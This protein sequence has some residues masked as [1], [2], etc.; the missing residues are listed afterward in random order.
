MQ[1]GYIDPSAGFAGLFGSVCC[2]LYAIPAM[3]A[4]AGT[5][6]WI[7]ALVDVLQRKDW[8]FPSA[9]PGSNDRVLWVLV[10]LFTHLIGA[11]IYYVVVMRPYPRAKA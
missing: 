11:I 10:V 6:L 1:T 7:I 8:E 9:Q 4:V 3:I 2:F 5:V